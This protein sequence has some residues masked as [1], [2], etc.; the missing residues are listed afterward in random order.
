M[1]TEHILYAKVSDS[2]YLTVFEGLMEEVDGPDLRTRLRLCGKFVRW[3]LLIGELPGGISDRAGRSTW[4]VE[5]LVSRPLSSQVFLR[6]R[7]TR[8]L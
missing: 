3:N 8:L 6:L 7:Y 2:P 1:C 5:R 4:R